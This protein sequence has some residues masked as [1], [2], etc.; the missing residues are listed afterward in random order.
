MVHLFSMEASSQ[1]QWTQESYTKS[2]STTAFT[3]GGLKSTGFQLERITTQLSREV[4]RRQL[5]L[6]KL[7]QELLSASSAAILSYSDDQMHILTFGEAH[8][9]MSPLCTHTAVLTIWCSVPSQV[10]MLQYKI[11]ET[12]QK[13]TP[14]EKVVFESRVKTRAKQPQKVCCCTRRNCSSCSQ[15]SQQKSQARRPQQKITIPISS[16]LSAI[17]P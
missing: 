9:Q 15:Q 5:Q 14:I 8:R 7:L 11:L 13:D 16:A 6:A 10:D 17:I 4:F 3:L 1:L 2:K 12:G